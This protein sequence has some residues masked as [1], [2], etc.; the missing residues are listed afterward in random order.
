MWAKDI[1]FLIHCGGYLCSVA[2]APELK[3]IDWENI[4]FGL[5]NTDYMYV[6]KCTISD[7]FFKGQLQRFGT[8]EVNPAAGVLNYGQVCQETLA[9]FF[10]QHRTFGFHRLRILYLY[11]MI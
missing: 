10:T 6:A 2:E 8:I 4:G 1:T 3:D 11:D 5:V 9:G 7:P